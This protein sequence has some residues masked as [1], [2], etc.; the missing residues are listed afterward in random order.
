V[1]FGAGSGGAGGLCA[2]ARRAAYVTGR[3]MRR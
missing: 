1:A 2:A 3:T